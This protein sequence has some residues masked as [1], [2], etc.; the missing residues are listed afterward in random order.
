MDGGARALEGL[1]TAGVI[2]LFSFWQSRQAEIRGF[3]ARR[4]VVHEFG[5]AGEDQQRRKPRGHDIHPASPE[6][7]EVELVELSRLWQ[8]VQSNLERQVW[9][10]VF[11]HRTLD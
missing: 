9:C 11:S 6:V 8:G 1:G 2:A 4:V 3:R 10:M 7:T 5:T